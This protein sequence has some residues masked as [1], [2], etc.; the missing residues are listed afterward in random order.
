MA[1]RLH[2]QEITILDCTL[3]DG[4]FYNNWNFDLQKSKKL[5]HSLANAGVDIIEIGYKTIQN[6]KFYGLFKFSNEKFLSYLKDVE[7]VE[8]AFM[9]DIKEF[10]NEDR[11]GLN[12]EALDKLVL[13]QKDSVFQWVRLVSKLGDVPFAAAYINYCKTKG[14]K[15]CFNIM[16]GS[17]ISDQ[18][19]TE[20]IQAV[21][22]TALDVFYIADSYGSFYPEQLRKK[23]QIMSKHFDKKLGV[24][25]HDNQGLAYA[26]SLIAIEEGVHFIDATVMGMGRG[27]GNLKLEQF[28]LGYSTIF[29]RKDIQP[30]QLLSPIK[31][32]IQ[33]LWE[34]YKWGFNYSYMLSG[35]N[36][37]HQSYCQTL[38]QSNRYTN[39]QI[40]NILAK[41]PTDI[42][43]KFDQKTL[44]KS[45]QQ[46]L[47]TSEVNSTTTQN[48]PIWESKNRLEKVLII[49]GGPSAK[50]M[51]E[52]VAQMIASTDYQLIECN[53]TGI[54]D[55]YEEKIVAILN[56]LKL[57][58]YLENNYQYK[59]IVT[60][61]KYIPKG[62]SNKS[63]VF[64]IPFELGA[65]ELT[66]NKLQIPDYDVGMFAI[67]F[68]LMNGAKEICLAGFDGRKK[69]TENANMESFFSQLELLADKYEVDIKIITPTHYKNI[70]QTSIYSIF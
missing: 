14:Y 6:N 28:L 65:L 41:I 47:Q 2:P 34:K 32:F 37:I 57:H 61:E 16:G 67:T 54:L 21:S 8:F 24:H 35:L 49:G 69:E 22:S 58:S 18:E 7:G 40:T 20:T 3:R 4:G 66:P 39:S 25:L 59:T 43:P 36:N 53:H 26:N 45:I 55:Q 50:E 48:L 5:V 70:P 56:K 46:M 11:N 52:S 68:A 23:I 13:P 31:D 60:G 17:M 44:D 63:N 29:D 15:V 12:Y 10:I 27:A 9:I 62:V 1:N 42:R 51:N 30:D 33:P 19:L 64:S 38:S